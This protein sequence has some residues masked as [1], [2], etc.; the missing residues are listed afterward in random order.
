MTQETRKLK[1]L[2]VTV[3]SGFLGAGKT[4][5]LNHVLNNRD[6]LRVAVIVNDMSEVNI[7][8]QLVGDGVA[9]SRT[10]ET[11]VELTNGC[12]CCTL[13]E[14]LLREVSRL[15]SEDRFDHLLIES[16][17]VSEPMPV[18][19]TFTFAD[20]SGRQLADV[21]RL[22]A[23][24]TVVD[25]HNFLSECQSRDF[26]KERR[27]ATRDDDNR[28]IANLL[29][30]QVEFASLIVINK[31]DLVDAG[32][33][34]RLKGVL[35]HLNPDAEVIT[36]SHG[37][38]S[39]HDFMYTGSFD[40]EKARRAPGWLKEMRGEHVPENVEYGIRNFVYRA[41]RPFHPQRFHEHLNQPWPGVIRC[42]GFIW[43]ASR[44]D[45]V[46]YWQQAGPIGY[47]G[48]TGVWWAGV[49]R[50]QWPNTPKGLERIRGNWAEPFGDRRQEMVFIGVGIDEANITQTLDSCL[51]NDTEMQAGAEHWKNLTDPF[52]AW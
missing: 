28:S 26:F 2:P 3:L 47:T 45:A 8:A 27:L 5:L 1:L 18:A 44:M 21:A 22:D 32:D 33:L 15:A 31:A 17:G 49:P 51:L 41:R 42:K 36:T 16:T 46:G 29:I 7:D 14:D 48:K 9:L 13:R 24:V 11:L 39:V 10:E 4:T 38:V 19:E 6:G 50:D 34:A 52:A 30:D 40:I 35:H 25:A 23:M 43:L 20:E 37:K 12:I